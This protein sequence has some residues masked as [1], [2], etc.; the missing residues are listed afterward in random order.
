MTGLTTS[1]VLDNDAKTSPSTK[2]ATPSASAKVIALR[3]PSRWHDPLQLI[4]D[5]AP[6]KT[7]RIVLWA[8]CLFVLLLIVWAAFGKLDIIATAE[9]K[10]VPRTLVKIVQ[11]AE[12]GIVRAIL[13]N[14]GDAVTAGQVVARLDPTVASADRASVAQD[15]ARQTMHVRR[16][17][18]QL[19]DQP[20]LPKSGDDAQLYAEVH[21][22]YLAHRRAM[23][24]SLDQERSLLIKA[25]QE[26]QSAQQILA[27]FE[28]TLP[29]YEKAA[30]AYSVLQQQ[31]F[32][33][34]LATDEKQREVIEKTR[35]RDAQQSIVAAATST[36]SAQEKRLTQLLSSYRSELQ[37]EL[38]VVNAR[39]A[40]LRPELHKAAYREQLMELKAPQDGIIQ[41]L[42][43]TTVGAVV[44]P[45]TVLMT[46]VPQQEEL[47]A[48]VQIRNED[49]GFVKVGQNAQVKLAAYPFQK[50]GLVGGEDAVLIVDDTA[51]PKQGRHSVGVKRQHCGVL[52]KQAN[53]QVLVSLTLSRQEVPVPIGLQLYLPEDWAH[54]SARRAAAKVPESIPF[55]TKGTIAMAQIDAAIADGVRFGVVAADAGYGSSSAF[56]N[57]LTQRGLLWAVGVQPMQKVYPADVEF[58]TSVNPGAGRPAKYPRMSTPSVSVVQMI[59]SLGPHA[60]QRCSWRSGTKGELSAHFAA[61]RVRIADGLLISHG[62]HLPGQLAWLVCEARSSGERKYYFTNHPSEAVLVTLVRAIKARWSCEQAHQQLKDELGLDHYEGRSWIGLHHHALLTLIAF[63]YLQ[64]RRLQSAWQSGKKIN[65]RCAGSATAA[66]VASRATGSDW[67]A[68]LC[69]SHLLPL[70][71]SYH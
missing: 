4:Q 29:T 11:P 34:S 67:H 50:Y 44:Q 61:V 12:S 41:D 43:T 21:S 70:L 1:T 3:P 42:A 28:Q 69:H 31:G 46:L 36:I 35:D 48:D 24:D 58:N 8:V 51:L 71:R 63:A 9:G 7:G 2:P 32:F 52:G 18:A 27:K 39:T 65:R 60:L 19:T 23:T 17:N 14:E 20:M 33:S 10:L 56:R 26:R 53:C 62:Q 6:H 38:A 45:G 47:V 66:V 55:A 59:D 57:G 13:V 25:E 54:D 49:I 30:Q 5:Q 37:K 22:Q 15:L 40:Q 64:H 68:C 16:L